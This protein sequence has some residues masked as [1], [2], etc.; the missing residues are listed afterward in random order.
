MKEDM[1]DF[2]KIENLLLSKK[3]EELSPPELREVE[4]YFESEAEYTDMRQTLMQVKDTL[5]EDKTLIV[6]SVELKE[7]LL[8]KFEETHTKSS[9]ATGKT[10]PFY[11]TVW[12]QT[13]AAASVIIVIGLGI[14]NSM[15]N[16][17]K[18]PQEK[19]MALN[20]DQN[21]REE[22]PARDNTLDDDKI[23]GP[24]A[25]DEN[26]D[27]PLEFAT[28]IEDKPNTPSD[29]GDGDF[30]PI[31]I[32]KHTIDPNNIPQGNEM[33]TIIETD[34]EE[35]F[36]NIGNTTNSSFGDFVPAQE[37]D[38]YDN[39]ADT[40]SMDGTEQDIYYFNHKI[41]PGEGGKV[42]ESGENEGQ[43][44][45]NINDESDDNSTG[46]DKNKGKSDNIPVMSNTS[47]GDFNQDSFKKESKDTNTR[48]TNAT[49]SLNDKRDSID[50]NMYKD[51]NMNRR[52]KQSL[53]EMQ[54]NDP[55]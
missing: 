22:S 43:N 33:E 54:E 49:D 28:E 18:G 8:K 32:R 55:D 52:A 10:R 46:S 24:D 37:K 48:S 7:N 23:T 38:R 41:N 11:R 14:F 45:V 5:A 19:D 39:D 36:D 16:L 13:A 15:N 4:A 42:Q 47:T 34:S 26:D 1:K 20:K 27:P 9:A 40:K 51:N 44:N 53:D 31:T 12:F 50:V 6:P 17:D 25:A 30:G 2:E 3:Y 35:E 21:E 29:N